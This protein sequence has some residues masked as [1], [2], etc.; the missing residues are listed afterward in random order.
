M[1][2]APFTRSDGRGGVSAAAL[3][4][5][6]LV[7]GISPVRAQDQVQIDG[8]ILQ[9]RGTLA[10]C[11][12]AAAVF[13]PDGKRILTAGHDAAR[14]WDAETLGPMTEPLPHARVLR[15]AFS[16]DGKLLLTAGGN[17]VR[18]WE[19]ATGRPV[20]TLA[21]EHPVCSAAF[22]PDGRRI[23]TGS[24]DGRVWDVAAGRVLMTLALGGA[25]VGFVVYSPRGDKILGLADTHR[26]GAGYVWDAK[27]GKMLAGPLVEICY[28]RSDVF[29]PNPAAFSPDATKVAGI[30]FKL[31][32]IWDAGTGNVVVSAQA[33]RGDELGALSS[34][35]FSPDGSRLAVGKFGC[36]RIFDV[37]TGKQIGDDIG[38]AS[39]PYSIAFTPDG[40]RVVANMRN[41][42]SGMFDVETTK[43][44]FWFM[45][46]KGAG[47]KEDR[48]AAPVMAM[49]S[50][51]KCIAGGWAEGN[52]TH[53]WT[54]P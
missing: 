2:P 34:A 3:A 35:N 52:F 27:T 44:L 40:K 1:T 41:S 7:L 39:F 6:I 12:G 17:E 50:D 42:E 11:S 45:A 25:E 13:S 5:T 37:R 33:W 18:L 14:V 10:G 48:D 53:A 4:Y 22:S 19:T 15:A 47:L 9:P 43:K 32:T 26:N 24:K 20:G 38:M 31:A 51:G 8:V 30:N 49:S 16:R 23:V 36:I 28:E 29:I 54:L 46:G 21:H